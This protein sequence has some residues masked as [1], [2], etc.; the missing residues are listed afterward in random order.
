MILIQS[1]R[2]DVDAE[3]RFYPIYTE[4]STKALRAIVAPRR[5]IST[6]GVGEN[7]CKCALQQNIAVYTAH[8]RGAAMRNDRAA[9]G[10]AVDMPPMKTFPL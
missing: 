4:T 8:G 6:L 2:L 9:Y 1:H 7:L 5:E 10:K 3:N